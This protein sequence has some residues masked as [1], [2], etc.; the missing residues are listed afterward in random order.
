MDEAAVDV[1]AQAREWLRVQSEERPKCAGCDGHGRRD[2]ERCGAFVDSEGP[3]IVESLLEHVAH[4]DVR[5]AEVTAERDGLTEAV[6]EHLDM[7]VEEGETTLEAIER[8]GKDQRMNVGEYVAQT[9]A[10]ERQRGHIP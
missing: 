7:N 9:M 1:L 6:Y 3:R 10:M 4:L 8:A 2:C 5:V